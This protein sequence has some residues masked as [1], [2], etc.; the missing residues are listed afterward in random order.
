MRKNKWRTVVL[1]MA[2]AVLVM[3]VFLYLPIILNFMNSLYKWGA[4]SSEVT[5]VGLDNYIRMFHD[6]VFYIAVKN[7]LIFVITSVIFQIGVSLVIAA[8]LES[9]F[10]RK[11]QTLF[12]TIY[13]VPSLLMV[14]VTGITFKMLYNPSIGLLN[15]ML[16]ALGIDTSNI[17]I[18]GNA[19]TAI[20]GVA[21]ASQ[22][23]Y[24][25]YT[26]ILFIVAMQGIPEDLYEAADVD[27]AN[28]IQKFFRITVPQMKNTIMINMIIIITGAVRVYDEVYV[29]TGGGPGKATQTLATYLY[30]EGFK[31]DQMGYASAIAFFIFAVTFVL[32]LMQMKGYSLDE[33]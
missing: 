19:F 16:N 6:D 15:P 9:R 23:Q 30:Q 28:A 20:W 24:V 3:I 26:I 2:P 33:E 18:L 27:G 12:R 32:G 17:D 14:T 10:M 1:Y 21:A 29:M 22:W 7:N 11:F 25:G 13:F 4:I 5:F 31:N 8:V